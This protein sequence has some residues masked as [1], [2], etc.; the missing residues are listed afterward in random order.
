MRSQVFKNGK[1]THYLIEIWPIAC[2]R[3]S[4]CATLSVG[5]VFRSHSTSPH[6]CMSAMHSGSH[7]VN[8]K[9]DTSSCF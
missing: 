8:Q 2:L 3:S 6:A 4:S 5:A 1:Q 7:P 9:D